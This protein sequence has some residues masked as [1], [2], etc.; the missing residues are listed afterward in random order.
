MYN[1]GSVDQSNLNDGLGST[2]TYVAD[3]ANRMTGWVDAPR[4]SC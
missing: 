2:A 4:T 1:S 3:I